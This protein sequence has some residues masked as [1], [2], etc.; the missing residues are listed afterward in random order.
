M[1]IDLILC[2]LIITDIVI[3]L[4]LNRHEVAIV[5]LLR[6]HPELLEDDDE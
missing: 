4:A 3:I 6:L 2:A 5:E 1:L